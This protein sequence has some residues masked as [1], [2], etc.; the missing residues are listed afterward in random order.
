MYFRD[1]QHF[2]PATGTVTIKSFPDKV[3][4]FIDFLWSSG[5]SLE[6]YVDL[7]EFRVEYNQILDKDMQLEAH[8][9]SY[10]EILH[11]IDIMRISYIE[12]K[13]NL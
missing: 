8:T 1:K 9:L 5:K 2:L 4:K 7:K 10:D 6:S 11:K 3:Q 12:A 13:K